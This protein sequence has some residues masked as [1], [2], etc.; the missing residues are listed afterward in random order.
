MAPSVIPDYLKNV[1]AKFGSVKGICTEAQ[2][3]QDLVFVAFF[4][5]RHARLAHNALSAGDSRMMDVH[6]P[7]KP[8]AFKVDVSFVSTEE[9]SKVRESA[10]C[11][12]PKLT[13]A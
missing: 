7:A 4:D 2:Q 6:L 11:Y 9:M 10:L 5:V 13:F 8:G 1:F 12:S 3:T